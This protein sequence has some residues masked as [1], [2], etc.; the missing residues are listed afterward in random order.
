MAKMKYPDGRKNRSQA[1]QRGSYK[2][3]GEPE[4]RHT[5]R[6][7]ENSTK[8]CFVYFRF[9]SGAGRDKKKASLDVDSDCYRGVGHRMGVMRILLAF[10]KEIPHAGRHSA[11]FG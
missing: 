8:T 4:M 3:E 2:S 5:A 10:W 11:A 1:E 6:S 7:N 9:C